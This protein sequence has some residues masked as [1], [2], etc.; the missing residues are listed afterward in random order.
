MHEHSSNTGQQLGPPCL[1]LTRWGSK[2]ATKPRHRSHQK[3]L[4]LVNAAGFALGTYRIICVQTTHG[5]KIHILSDFQDT[6]VDLHMENIGN[7]ILLLSMRTVETAVQRNQQAWM[8]LAALWSRV[9][10]PRCLIHPTATFAC[11][12]YGTV[13]D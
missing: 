6:F 1:N 2:A 7:D 3:L 8:R 11:V 13:G 12:N 5:I 4:R 10:I 9:P